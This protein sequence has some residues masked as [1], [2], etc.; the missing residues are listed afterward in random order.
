MQ[1]NTDIEVLRA[2]AVGVVILHHAKGALISWSAPAALTTFFTYFRGG[3]GVDLFFVISGFVIAR[4]LLNNLRIAQDTGQVSGV[5][6][7]FWVRRMFRIFPLA[8]FWLAFILFATLVL[9]ETGVFHS[10]RANWEGTVAAVLQVANFRIE[11][12]FAHFDCGANFVYWSLSLEEQF[13][14]ALPLLALLLRQYLTAFLLVCL[15]Y[16]LWSVPLAH[17][18]GFRVEGLL[19]GVLLA[20]WSDKPSYSV[21]E[22][23]SLLHSPWAGFAAF[24]G[25][26]ILLVSIQSPELRT[27][28]VHMQSKV[29]ALVAALMVWLASYDRDYLMPFSWLKAGFLWAGSRS[30]AL[31]LVHIPAFY[32]TRELWFRFTGSEVPQ[33]S[34]LMF[35]FGTAFFFLVFFS[36]AS[37]RL[38]ETPMRNKGIVISSRILKNGAQVV[39]PGQARQG[40]TSSA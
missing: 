39:P 1:K 6:K 16:K 24:M 30:Y 5:L 13:Y 25:L 3:V 38:I 23:R 32:L 35:Y 10:F 34:D 11:A 15:A 14:I 29:V 33:S 27:V 8:W 37:F 26:S 22:P 40:V 18:F 17:H 19:L 2:L 7:A 12:C 9:N 20:I 31:Y 28:P 36:E 21:F 4:G